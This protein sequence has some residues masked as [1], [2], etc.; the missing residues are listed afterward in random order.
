MLFPKHRTPP[1]TALPG[2]FAEDPWACSSS[3]LLS[4]LLSLEEVSFLA[5]LVT[6]PFDCDF[7]FEAVV[8]LLM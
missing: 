8:D 6:G 1:C 2:F 5:F 4:S 3:S 7:R